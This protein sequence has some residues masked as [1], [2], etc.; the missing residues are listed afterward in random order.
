VKSP[1][2]T[3]QLPAGWE[4]KLVGRQ[5]IGGGGKCSLGGDEFTPEGDLIAGAFASRAE[6]FAPFSLSLNG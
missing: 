6:A 5:R 2:K 1:R 3:V 4:C